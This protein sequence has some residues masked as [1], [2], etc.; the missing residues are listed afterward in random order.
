MT[1]KENPP[2]YK[3]DAGSLSTISRWDTF[4]VEELQEAFEPEEHVECEEEREL[5]VKIGTLA[6]KNIFRLK[7]VNIPETSQ[8]I[9]KI[10]KKMPISISTRK[11][12]CC[13]RC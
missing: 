2:K 5:S 11:Y 8:R 7:K 13:R 6:I 4:L 12:F 3:R 1:I 9:A 10:T